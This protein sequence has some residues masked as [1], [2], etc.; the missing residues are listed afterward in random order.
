MEG[1]EISNSEC[2]FWDFA[3]LDGSGD[4]S[5][6]GCEQVQIPGT[7]RVVCNCDHLTSFAVIVVSVYNL[8]ENIHN[9][10]IPHVSQ[11]WLF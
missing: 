6:D 1:E 4:W 7:D 5:T 11:F 9:E 10:S 3:A 2:V 8:R